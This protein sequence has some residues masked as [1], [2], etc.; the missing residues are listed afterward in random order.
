MQHQQEHFLVDALIVWSKTSSQ[1][2]L[3][4]WMAVPRR[5]E[6]LFHGWKPCVLTDRRRD[7]MY[8]VTCKANDFFGVYG[9]LG[10]FGLYGAPRRTWTSNLLITNQLLYQLSH[11]GNT[12][13]I[14]H[15]K[16]LIVYLL[17][18]H[19]RLYTHGKISSGV[20]VYHLLF[21]WLNAMFLKHN[22]HA[23]N[24]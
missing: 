10:M 15:D 19:R 17:N 23:K 1:W 11:G 18:A 2:Y 8:Q 9:N 6:L 3:K 7:Q 20:V 12:V 4:K 14:L 16:H 24:T 5:I 22:W 21:A 13:N